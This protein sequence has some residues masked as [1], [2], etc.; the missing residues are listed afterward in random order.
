MFSC[1]HVD[2]LK[3]WPV[4]LSVCQTDVPLPE[5]CFKFNTNFENIKPCC[6]AKSSGTLHK[7][8]LEGRGKRINL[9]LHNPWTHSQK[10]SSVITLDAEYGIMQVIGLALS[11]NEKNEMKIR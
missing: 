1:L 5:R 7:E 11:V 4:S 3:T 8:I 2:I 9:H 6:T 10:A